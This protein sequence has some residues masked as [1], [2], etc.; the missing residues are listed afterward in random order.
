MTRACCPP[1]AEHASAPDGTVGLLL[2]LMLLGDGITLVVGAVFCALATFALVSKAA[3]IAMAVRTFMALL[4]VAKS[5]TLRQRAPVELRFE[6]V[7]WSHLEHDPKSG[8]R[9]SRKNMLK[10]QANAKRFQL[11][12]FSLLPHVKLR[13]DVELGKRFSSF[14]WTKDRESALAAS[15]EAAMTWTN[16]DD[17]R[18]E[19]GETELTAGRIFYWLTTLVA[20]L[21]LIFAV[22]DFFISWAQGTPIVRVFALVAA[23]GVWLIG[24]AVRAL[25]R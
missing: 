6:G 8:N 21:M 13:R 16:H 12:P 25:L 22:A 15:R 1:T 5:I 20:A 7:I 24:R 9:F 23:A 10:Q 17:V 19:P 4:H 11:I 14:I 18:W 2:L 3:A